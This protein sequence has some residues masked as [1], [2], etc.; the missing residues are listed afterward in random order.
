MLLFEGQ[1]PSRLVKGVIRMFM[2]RWAFMLSR[3]STVYDGGGGQ[4]VGMSVID[5]RTLVFVRLALRVFY[6]YLAVLITPRSRLRLL[7][8]T[9][10]LG[11]S[12]LSKNYS[13]CFGGR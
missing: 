4:R 2:P 11:A 6:M 5:E 9:S 8:C 7:F 10:A 1:Q 12:S 13:Y 3:C